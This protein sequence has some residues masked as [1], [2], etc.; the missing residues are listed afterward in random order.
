MP[1]PEERGLWGAMV[2]RPWSSLSIITVLQTVFVLNTRSLW[3]SDEVRYA[4]AYEHLAR[5]GKWLVLYLNGAPYPDKPPVYFWFLALLDAATPADPPGLFFLGAALSGLLFVLA[6]CVL[7]RALGLD[8]QTGLGAG[9]VLLSALFFAGIMHYSR[10]DLFFAAL[11]VLSQAC[12]FKACTRAQPNRW[13]LCGMALAAAATL[14]KGPL[15]LA[16]PLLSWALFA[17]WKGELRRLLSARTLKALALFAAIVAAWLAGAMTV[18]GWDFVRNIL[19]KQ[20]LVRA[21][22]TFHHKEPWTYY[23]LAL[24]LAWLPWTLFGLAA[25]LKKTLPN[26]RR[27]LAGR[28]DDDPGLDAG[29]WLWI[30]AL[31]GFG[32]LCCLSGKVLI[33]ILPLFAPLAVLTAQGL[34][35]LDQGRSRRFFLAVAAFYL[36]LAA[37]GPFAE[38][39][40]PA[41][42]RGVGLSTLILA[43]GAALIYYLR[44]RPARTGL[45]AMALVTGLWIQPAALL[46]APSLDPVLSPRQQAEVM[47]GYAQQGYTPLA[48]HIY[49][50][51]YT[52]YLGQN[53]NEIDE[54]E[55][56]KETLEKHPR[57]VLVIRQKDWVPWLDGPGRLKVVHRQTISGQIYLLA[58]RDQSG[59][60]DSAPGPSGLENAETK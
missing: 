30:S 27:A 54:L 2:R 22:N 9:L 23:F 43:A 49:R 48:F 6:T 25:P 51:I 59:R 58:V 40:S 12:L 35:G 14:T 13:A 26:L 46:I 31:S 24:P 10:M 55:K 33:Y 52:Y 7:A 28:K 38:F 19:H 45:L 42:L 47:K 11:I 56:L 57:V 44:N 3:F 50:G 37:A 4:N 39:L 8:R 29:A 18:E 20:I 32:L 36:L 17:A 41:P 53:I 5:A 21:A 15:G 16:F 60:V 34:L 1:E